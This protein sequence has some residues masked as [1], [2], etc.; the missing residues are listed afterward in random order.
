MTTEQEQASEAAR[1]KFDEV[2]SLFGAIV[3]PPGTP[4]RPKP[5]LRVLPTTIPTAATDAPEFAPV[6]LPQDMPSEPASPS[7]APPPPKPVALVPPDANPVPVPAPVPDVVP[8]LTPVLDL[9]PVPAATSLRPAPPPAGAR[10]NPFRRPAEAKS[11]A[12]P[13]AARP[14]PTPIPWPDAFEPQPN[15]RRKRE[16]RAW[17][18]LLLAPLGVVVAIAVMM[19]DPRAIRS[20]INR[21]IL[22][23]DPPAAAVDTALLPAPFRTTRP[24]APGAEDSAAPVTGPRAVAPDA[25]PAATPPVPTPSPTV[26]PESVPAAS[27]PPPSPASSTPEPSDTPAIPAAPPAATAPSTASP[28][29][30]PPPL[31]TASP[32]NP[33]TGSADTS[34]TPAIAAATPT[35]PNP[36]KVI[37]QFRRNQPGAESDA[38]RMAALLQSKVSGVELHSSG[39]AT[40][41]PTINY[42]SPADKDAA[43]ALARS[44]ANEGSGWIVRAGTKGGAP[45]SLNLWLP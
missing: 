28:D 40:R 43:T 20:F 37:I 17:S 41:S 21:N 45:G 26:S 24:V 18:W 34:G 7:L 23:R 30:S 42:Y 31:P 33:T 9:A 1:R 44:L 39:I 16:E 2:T 3:P 6:P 15:F 11:P 10:T 13:P 38:R 14:Q 8:D 12:R 22:H 36:V 19:I 29:P 5:T 27:A 35:A 32:P 4:V 25:G